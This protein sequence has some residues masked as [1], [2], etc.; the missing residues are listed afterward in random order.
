MLPI[1]WGKGDRE[2]R[3][4]T[5]RKGISVNTIVVMRTS[6]RR[7]TRGPSDEL[8]AELVASLQRNGHIILEREDD[9]GPNEHYMQVWY[10]P[11]GSFQL[12]YRAG[13]P[14]EH[15]Q[16]RTMCRDKVRSALIEWNHGGDAWLGKFEW[17]SIGS[18]FSND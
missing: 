6:D 17:N 16:T 3:V 15:Y 11:D 4:C 12:E 10:R 13:R 1:T 8:V 5:S 9:S 14:S 2:I 18:W 7:V